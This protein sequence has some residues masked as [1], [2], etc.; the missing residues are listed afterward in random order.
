MT[1]TL[2]RILRPLAATL[3]ACATCGPLSGCGGGS[4]G[5][6][7]TGSYTS[8]DTAEVGAEF[9]S[10][11]TVVFSM[12]DERGKPGKYAVDGEKIVVDFNGQKVTFIRDGDCIEDLQRMFGKMCKGGAAGAAS[13]VS[14]RAPAPTTGNWAATNSDG[15]FTLAFQ[16]GDKLTFS[17]TPT[18]GSQMGDKPMST[19]GTFELEGDTLYINLADG[20]SMVLK[21]VN[22]AYDSTAFGLPMKFTKK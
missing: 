4:G 21:W 10:D 6:G 15:T 22:G 2:D 7:V 12:G 5:G 14:T 1:S 20:G 13:N 16:S 9:R 18:A 8:V 11:G 17:M 19:D 3:L